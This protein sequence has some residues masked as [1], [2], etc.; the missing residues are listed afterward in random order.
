MININ[1]SIA[2]EIKKQEIRYERHK[3]MQKLDI[4]FMQ[5][6][7]QNNEAL[8]EEIMNKKQ[9]L[10]DATDEIGIETAV[11]IDELKSVRPSILDEV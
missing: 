9:R 8:K 1:M 3:K 10:R 2:K 4:E 5:A 11:S 7:E 6:L